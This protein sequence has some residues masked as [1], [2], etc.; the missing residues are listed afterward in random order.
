[1]TAA[2]VAASIDHGLVTG[3]ADDDHTQYLL[4]DGTRAL[5]A[6]WAAGA[7]DITLHELTLSDNTITNVSADLTYVV[8]N[9]RKHIFKVAAVEVFRVEPTKLYMEY[10]LDMNTADIYLDAGYSIRY[11]G[12]SDHAFVPYPAADYALARSAGN[13]VIQIDSDNNATTNF[14]EVRHNASTHTG[15]TSLWKIEEDGDITHTGGYTINGYVSVWDDAYQGLEVKVTESVGAGA[16]FYAMVYGSGAA[17]LTLYRAIGTEASPTPVTNNAWLGYMDYSGYAHSTETWQVGARAYAKA[18]ELWST[19]G[20]GTTYIIRT[21]KTTET[22]LGDRFSVEGDGRCKVFAELEI[23]GD[24]N[25]DGSNIG[26]FATAPTTQ[27]TVTGSRAG[28]AALAD[29]LTKLANY[30]LIVDSTT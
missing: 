16:D 18:T 20:Y 4:H 19:S 24:F 29:L 9:V 25:H 10:T 21:T 8:D 11:N 15:G 22:A 6:N 3:L 13:F 2:Q 12:D 28:N 14:F 30:G 7:F 27:Q 26:F 17:S 23:D 1:V 5:T